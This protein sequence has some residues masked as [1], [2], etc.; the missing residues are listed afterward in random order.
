MADNNLTGTQ[1]HEKEVVTVEGLKSSMQEYKSQYGTIVTLSSKPTAATLTYQHNGK[2]YDFHVG[3]EVRVPDSENASEGSNG[4]VYYKLY[5]IVEQTGGQKTAYWDLGGSGGTGNVQATIKVALKEVVNDVERQSGTDIMGA[6][7]TLYNVTDS[8]AVGSQQWAGTELVWRK[9]TPMKDY[10]LDFQAVLGQ[11]PQSIT[12]QQI[13]IGEEQQRQASYRYDE[14][15][16]SITSNQ[17]DKTAISAAKVTV[18]YGEQSALLGNGETLMV[19]EGTTVAA[20]AAGYVKGYAVTPQLTGKTVVA[21]YEATTT[22]VTI[23]SNQ[24]SDA[25]IGALRATVAWTYDGHTESD[26]LTAATAQVL[27]PTGVTPMVTFPEAPTGYSRTISQDGLTAT[28]QTTLVTV[29]VSQQDGQDADIEGATVTVTDQTAEAQV[30]PAG[31]VYMIPTGHTYQVAVSTVQGY[32][33]PT[34]TALVAANAAEQVQMTYVYNPIEFGYIILDQTSSD[35]TTKVLDENGKT[36]SQGYQRPSVIDSIRRDS[37]CYVG[38]FANN[39]MHLKQLDDTDGTKYADGTSAA[40][41]IASTSKDVFMRL[42]EFYT[43]ATQ[44]ETDKWKIEF[45]YGG[46]PGTGWKKWGGNDLIGKYKGYDASSKLYSISGV[47]STANISQADFK[48]HAR[49]KGTGFSIVKWRHQNIMAILFYAYYGHTNCQQLLG[50]GANSRNRVTGQK[51]SL[52]MTDTTSSNGNTNNIVFWGLENWW[53]DLYEWVDNVVVNNHTWTITEDDNTTRTIQSS[54]MASGNDTT[55]Y[56]SKFILGDDLDVIAAAGQS[57]GSDSQGYCDGQYYTSSNSRVV[58][59]S[60]SDAFT[61]GG[62]AFVYAFTD[63]SYSY[64]Y[65]GSRLAFTGAIEIS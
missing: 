59:R 2:T 48:S 64:S 49:A 33:T 62:V 45:A 50:T 30:T 26:T 55:I 42:P 7:V 36:Y 53:G 25:T 5:D 9:L 34:H 1:G 14:Y 3:D 11:Q 65:R 46:N 47:A 4:Y 28:Y 31:G 20:I 13:G 40:S 24:Q 10:R 56:P 15:T 8:V 19:S 17:T 29:S 18:E 43:K 52:G 21:A 57:G 58:A 35:P 38:T 51:N 44:V 22:T 60:C 16:A 6:E 41:D 54:A 27:V 39:V 37:H 32:T 61:Y 12:I 23:L 63:S